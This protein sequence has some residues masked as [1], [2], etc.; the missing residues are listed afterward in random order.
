[1]L[2]FLYGTDFHGNT[3]KFETLLKYAVQMD[4]K[5]IHLGADILPKTSNIIHAQKV[6]IKD[7]LKNYYR[8]CSEYGITVLASF[9]NDDIYIN[10]PEFK[11]YGTLLNEI[12]YQKDDYEFKAYNYVPIYPFSLRTACKLDS[13]DW[14]YTDRPCSTM[15]VDHT[16][17]IKIEDPDK[18]FKKKGTIQDDL[19]NYT[20]HKN[21][22]MSIHCPPSG[23]GLDICMDGRRVGSQAVYDW[24]RK[25][26]PLL[27]L[28]GHIHENLAITNSWRVMIGRTT[29]IQPGPNMV[30]INIEDNKVSC[31]LI[32]LDNRLWN[33][34]L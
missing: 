9:G 19:K 22:I 5:L 4:F 8:R 29:I 18:Y 15:D 20:G 13:K 2:R 14:V 6:F 30:V 10:M 27:S 33:Q 7:Y 26:A 23:L 24:I 34:E 17:F 16:G 12:P 11:K 3:D 28:H 21:L 25:E 1:M 31:E 32:R